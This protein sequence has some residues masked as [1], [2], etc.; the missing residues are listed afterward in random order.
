MYFP[1]IAESGLAPRM[2]AGC[3]SVDHACK[4]VLDFYHRYYEAVV[5]SYCSAKERHRV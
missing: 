1:L 2:V 4:W 3:I 5:I